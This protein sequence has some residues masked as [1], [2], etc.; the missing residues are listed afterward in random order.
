MWRDKDHPQNKVNKKPW[1]WDSIHQEAFDSVIKTIT[2]EVI[3]VYPDFTKPFDIYTDA[4]TKQLGAVIIQD[5]R[6][7]VFFSWKLS[8]AQSKYTVT[9]LELLA[10]VETLK[11]FK[12]MLWRQ[13]LNV[14]TDHKNLTREGLGLTSSRVTRWRIFLEE[15]DPEIIYIIGIHNTVAD[16]IS[17]LDYDPKFNS[18]ND[19]NHA[20]YGMSTKEATSQRWLMFSKLWSCYNEP[21]EDPGKTDIIQMNKVFTNHSKVDK[22]DPLTV[23]EIADAQKAD[24]KLK[25]F[26][27]TMQL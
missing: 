12:R 6:P 4:S 23:T 10:I 5:N 16:A 1:Q 19:Y 18:T 15:Y 24:T 17:R 21:Q 2:K 26:F 22:I 14:Y 13:K 20:M 9:K 3:L 8:G 7:I 27:S 25:Q 11:D